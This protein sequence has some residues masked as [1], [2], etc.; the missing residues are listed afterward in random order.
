MLLCSRTDR[1]IACQYVW[2]GPVAR[3]RK[4][5]AKRYGERA[6]ETIVDSL[7]EMRQQDASGN[8]SLAHRGGTIDYHDV[9]AILASLVELKEDVHPVDCQRILNKAVFNAIKEDAISSD[10]LLNSISQEERHF[11]STQRKQY[12]LATY[13]S[14]DATN[15]PIKRT[16][17]GSSTITFSLTH[18]A[19]VNYG[20]LQF[21]LD[22]LGLSTV[23]LNWLAVRVSE[24]GRTPEEAGYR[25]MENFETL[26]AIWNLARN[27]VIGHRMQTPVPKPV[28]DIRIGLVQ[29][30]HEPTGTETGGV[31]WYNEPYLAVDYPGRPK[32]LKNDE[33]AQI[34]KFEQHARQKLRRMPYRSKFEALL[35]EYV[36]ILDGVDH[37]TAVPRLWA[38]LEQLTHCS[39]GGGVNYDK[40]VRRTIFI[41]KESALM[42]LI[43]E[44]LRDVRNDTIHDLRVHNEQSTCFYQLLAMVHQMIIFHFQFSG[45]FKNFSEAGEFL[46]LSK[47]P[48]SLRSEI[49]RREKAL[50]FLGHATRRKK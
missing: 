27:R 24:Q 47:D 22:N 20:S 12:M 3:V 38:V 23:P 1:S 16:R 2:S 39:E 8:W 9:S 49:R 6:L 46:Q 42:R 29:T 14:I 28:N 41:W 19:G 31:F 10:S 21:T 18:P 11:R 43:L 35:R 45:E 50:Q 13:I 40:L 32:R 26:R 34:H 48:Q 4:S 30:V 36:A 25:A 37:Q 5:S 33:W 44:H 7:K 17:W 15:Q